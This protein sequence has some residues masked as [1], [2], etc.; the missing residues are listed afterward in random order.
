MAQKPEQACTLGNQEATQADLVSHAM[1]LQ[2]PSLQR[3]S[4]EL[5]GSMIWTVRVMLAFLLEMERSKTM[6]VTLKVVPTTLEV[7]T[8]HA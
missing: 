1:V 8:A 6:N 3:Y 5:Q 2:V 7:F 4:L